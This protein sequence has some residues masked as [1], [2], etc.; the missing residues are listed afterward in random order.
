[1]SKILNPRVGHGFDVHRFAL[2]ATAD[3]PLVLGGVTLPDAM[4]LEAHSDGDV[5]LHALCDALLGAI[6]EGDIGLHFP[7]TDLAFSGVSSGKLLEQVWQLVTARGLCL[8][9]ADITVVAELPKLSPH[10]NAMR[11]QIA[12]TLGVDVSTLNVKA[13]TTEKLGAIGRGE[14]I[15][16]HAIVLL[17]PSA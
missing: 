3:K 7:D 12:S 1:M 16:C 6:G 4:S 17:Y 14:G 5:V 10:R 8:A 15:A 2:T 9:N 11:A 13:T